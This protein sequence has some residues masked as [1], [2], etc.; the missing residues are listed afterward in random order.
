MVTFAGCPVFAAPK[1]TNA[2]TMINSESGSATVLANAVLDYA[3]LD[4]SDGRVFRTNSY[5]ISDQITLTRADAVPDTIS[6]FTVGTTG[7]TTLVPAMNFGAAATNIAKWTLPPQ[8]RWS[9]G[10]LRVTVYYAAANAVGTK[11]VCRLSIDTPAPNSGVNAWDLQATENI[12]TPAVTNNLTPFTFAA[13]A[14]YTEGDAVHIEFA[15]L[16]ADAADD[17][18]GNL[19]ILFAVLDFTADGP[20]D[21]HWTVSGRRTS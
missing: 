7:A 5:L 13:T 8:I 14:A 2:V 21:N 12:P 4:R 18:T 16:G 1:S 15:R 11:S 3:V 19:Q 10:T 17:Q 20:S 6:P 9:D